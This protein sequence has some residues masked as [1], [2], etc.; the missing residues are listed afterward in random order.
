MKLEFNNQYPCKLSTRALLGIEKAL[1][2][3][4]INIIYK[5]EGIPKLNDL[6][7][8]LFYCMRKDNPKIRTLDD[9]INIYEDYLEDGGSIRGLMEFILELIKESGIMGKEGDTETSET[10]TD[11][12]N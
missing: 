1:G 7:T 12:K 8:I 11:S 10:E 2:D 4:P 6:L 3:N 5:S 9:T